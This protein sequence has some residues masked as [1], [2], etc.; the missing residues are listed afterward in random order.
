MKNKIVFINPIAW[1]LTFIIGT[2]ILL[3]PTY[4]V[5][6]ILGYQIGTTSFLIVFLFVSILLLLSCL[7]TVDSG[8]SLAVVLWCKKRYFLD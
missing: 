5:I 3:V 8:S 7:Y 1:V 4:F 6:A 2:I